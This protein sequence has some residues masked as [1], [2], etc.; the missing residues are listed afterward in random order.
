MGKNKNNS[1]QSNQYPYPPVASDTFNVKVEGIENLFNEK[2]SALDKRIATIESDEL[3]R[4]DRIFK[5]KTILVSVIL[6]AILGI[7]GT[8][9]T[10]IFMNK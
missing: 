7:I 8:L 6:G 1:D 5:W 3:V 4:Q 9:I 2:V 10:Q